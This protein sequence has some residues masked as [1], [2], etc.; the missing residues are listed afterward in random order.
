VLDRV[1]PVVDL[2]K[3]PVP[4]TVETVLLRDGSLF[5]RGNIPPD[6]VVRRSQALLFD[7]AES[8]R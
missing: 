4:F 2:S 7:T 6:E 1:N 5:L 3:A 8:V